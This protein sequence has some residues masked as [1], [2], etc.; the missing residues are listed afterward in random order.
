MRSS[1]FILICLIGLFL[2]GCRHAVGPT[3][4]HP[5]AP[6]PGQILFEEMQ[7]TS[8]IDFRLGYR[9][10]QQI[11]IKETSGHPV[12][13]LDADGDGRLDVLVAGPDRVTLYRNLGGWKFQP[14]AN[15]GF[16]QKGFWQGVAVGDVNNDG[17]PD[18][19]L[20]GYQCAALYLN[21]GN[22]RFRDVTSES[23]L[24]N[25]RF[26]ETSAAFADVDRDGRLDLY[27]TCYVDLSHSSGLCTYPGGVSTACNP[28]Q[29]PTQRGVFYRNL[30]G[31]RF[32]NATQAFGLEGAHGNGLG[33]AF[34][35]PNGS[36]YPDLYLANDEHL[37][38]LFVNQQ[39][40]RFV[41][42]GTSSGTAFRLDGA[43]QAGMGVDFGDYDNDGHED[44]VVTNY[45]G[46]PKSLYHNDTEGLF[47]NVTN[48]ANLG[49]ATLAFAGW[50]VKWVDLD[51]DGWLDLAIANGHPLHRIHDLDP[52]VTSS[53]RF[54]V[55]R[56]LGDDHLAERSPVGDSYFA[57]QTSVGNGLPRVIAGR[58]LCT[59]DLDNDGR[60]DLV[61]SDIEGQ[62]LLLRNTSTGTG[63]WLTVRLVGNR[64]TEGTQVVVRAGTKQWKRRSTTGGSYLSASDPRV[65]FGLGEVSKLDEVQVRWPDV[66]TTLLHDV[67]ADQELAVKAER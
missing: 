15:A 14:V 65:H 61:I 33:A 57:E 23:G 55:V 19:Y 66:K 56:S 32:A 43:A 64:V 16:R 31:A 40:H 62:P 18:I 47:T 42:T 3:P 50:G 30:G 29:L 46:E 35:Y 28:L 41:N 8:G 26:W 53:Q 11:G 60:I 2:A 10:G 24:E 51:N 36:D 20:C 22:G 9:P 48:S 38:D 12:A 63:H 39:G 21:T 44:I 6:P 45:L 37:C 25:T 52:S 27:V 34:G 1:G 54:Q 67:P 58:A 17:R 49:P 59:G 7:P 5:P 13:L 4:Q